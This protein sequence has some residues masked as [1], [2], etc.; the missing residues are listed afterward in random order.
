MRL[1]EFMNDFFN[2]ANALAT[3]FYPV[4]VINSIKD[5]H[6]ASNALSAAT[7]NLLQQYFKRYVEDILCLKGDVEKEV[8]RKLEGVIFY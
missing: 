4:L 8:L 1:D 3:L 6:I 7:M 2:N 5:K